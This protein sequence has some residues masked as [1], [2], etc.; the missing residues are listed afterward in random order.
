MDRE[1]KRALGARLKAA[2]IAAGYS[3]R[4]TAEE[5]LSLPNRGLEAY[6]QG[7]RAPDLPTALLLAALYKAHP[8]VLLFWED[9]LSTAALAV[10]AQSLRRAAAVLIADAD[11]LSPD[12]EHIEQLRQISLEVLSESEPGAESPHQ[13]KGSATRRTKLAQ[14][15]SKSG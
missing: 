1:E 11:M 14:G 12:A 9:A 6:E 13:G 5:M 7:Q 3:T 10:A 4:E 2:R 8:A 15:N